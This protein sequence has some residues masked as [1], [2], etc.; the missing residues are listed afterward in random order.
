MIWISE[1]PL[2]IAVIDT[3]NIILEQEGLLREYK[4]VQNKWNDTICILFYC[5]YTLCTLVLQLCLGGGG[6]GLGS[7][8]GGGGLVLVEGGSWFLLLCNIGGSYRSLHNSTTPQ[9]LHSRL[10][11]YSFTTVQCYWL[12]TESISNSKPKSHDPATCMV[13]YPTS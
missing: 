3:E 2:C 10:Y 9:Q 4:K 12:L 11:S 8:G 1:G 5:G 6:G 7:C 13:H